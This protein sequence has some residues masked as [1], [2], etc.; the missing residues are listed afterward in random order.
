MSNYKLYTFV[1]KDAGEV[2]RRTLVHSGQ[3]FE[4]IRV[5]RGEQ[6][7]QLKP[8]TPY[9]CLPVF[10]EDGKKLGGTLAIAKYLGEKFGLAAG[11]DAWT[12][13]QLN[14]ICDLVIE[15]VVVL[16][17]YWSETD[18]ELKKKKES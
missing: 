5:K 7:D 11:G 3:K 10:E 8:Q 4:D 1:Q 17:R 13:A 16:S 15:I 14:S 9:G 12:R 6:W 2:I 18:P